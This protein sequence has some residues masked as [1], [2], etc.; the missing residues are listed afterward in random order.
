MLAEVDPLIQAKQYAAATSKLRDL[1]A[2]LAGT[3]AGVKAREKLAALAADPEARKQLEAA[4]KAEKANAALATAQKLQAEKKDGLAYQRYKEIATQYPGTDAA[5][6]AAAAI[7]QYEKDPTFVKGVVNAQNESKAKALLGMADG[8]KNA[9]KREQAIKTYQDV[10]EQY[11]GTP[12]AATAK[13]ALA[14][15][16]S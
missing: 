15:L 14:E 3:P 8:Y 12:Q 4:D 16:G 2:K 7:A 10:I 9:G 5:K 11:P 13:K 1:S 6:S